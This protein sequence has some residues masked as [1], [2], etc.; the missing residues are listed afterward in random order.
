VGNVT[1]PMLPQAIGLAGDEQ[2]EIVQAGTSARATV[3]Q[4]ANLG[5]PTGPPGAGP[6]GPTGGPGPTG[7]SVT[8]P[9]GPAGTVSS[10]SGTANQ[11]AASPTTG[12]VVVSLPNNVVIPT[13]TSGDALTVNAVASA[14][15]I[16]ARAASGGFAGA[17]LTSAGGQNGIF[18]AAGS[19]SSDQ[20]LTVTNSSGST[21]FFRVVGDGGVLV[22]APTG[23]DQGIGTVNSTGLFVNGVVA[24]ATT[25]TFTASTVGLGGATAPCSWTLIGNS[26]T[27][28]VGP[29]TSTTSTSTS[30]SIG[31]LPS[32]IQPA[33][34]KMAA[35]GQGGFNSGS[36]INTVSAEA[37]GSTIIFLNN[38]VAAGWT[39]S[40]AKSWSPI[41]ALGTTIVYDIT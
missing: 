3:L 9:T 28:Y 31:G 21:N 10:V 33:T 4:I 20:S 29:P 15:A 39:G 36:F 12:A 25:G 27:L 34:A 40:A 16:T 17:F 7:P 1:I 22:G 32:A 35:M 8:G 23:G 19:S 37:S 24:S 30:L 26:V 41:L 14:N 2:I 11:V 38:G 18:I 5:G 13:P 6:T